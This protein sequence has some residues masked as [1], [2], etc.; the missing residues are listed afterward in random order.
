MPTKEIFERLRGVKP[1]EKMIEASRKRLTEMFEQEF[2]R[3]VERRN[4]A[5]QLE[6]Q[7]YKPFIEGVK[8]NKEHQALMKKASELRKAR[9]KEKLVVPKAPPAEKRVYVHSIGLTHTP[10]YDWPWT[11]SATDGS[12]MTPSV[13]ADQN[14]GNLSF[15]IDSGDGGG[16]AAVATAVGF[17]FQPAIE[18]LGIMQVSCN[19]AVNW[20]WWIDCAFDSGHS[21][22]WIGIYVGSYDFNG[23]Q[24]THID[25]RTTLWNEDRSFIA[26]AGD[27]GSNSGM[28][29]SETQFINSNSFYE[30]WVWCGGSVS[31]AGQGFLNDS[32][33]GAA[34]N[35]NVPSIHIEYWG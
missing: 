28:P 27:S 2:R 31:G 34:I 26:F 18:N 16:S 10:P 35:V 15:F 13:S 21:D 7:F 30:V 23:T 22:G 11:W 1:T 12:P 17:Y 33:G 32:Y 19:P 24:Y 20:Q 25:Q 3:S 5:S 4:R 6:K 8:D 29:L 9:A 14:A